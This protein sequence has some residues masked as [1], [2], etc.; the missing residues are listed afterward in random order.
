MTLVLHFVSHQGMFISSLFSCFLSYY[1]SF[2]RGPVWSS[3]TSHPS[4]TITGTGGACMCMWA[5]MYSKCTVCVCACVLGG[6]TL[7]SDEF[8]MT[9]RGLSTMVSGT[10]CS[11]KLKHK[12]QCIILPS[13][14]KDTVMN[15][16]SE[17]IT[18]LFK[19]KNTKQERWTIGW[20]IRIL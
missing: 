7:H 19:R 15:P 20:S 13:I 3:L 17:D 14:R 10:L 8:C 2:H 6:G 4:C 12:T 11:K 9:V 18:A 5:H 1:H 16:A